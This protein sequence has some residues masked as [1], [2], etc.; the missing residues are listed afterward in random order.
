MNRLLTYLI[1]LIVVLAIGYVSLKHISKPY[2]NSDTI[3]GR[4]S[5]ILNE[6]NKI[7]IECFGVEENKVDVSWHP[8]VEGKIIIKS[9]KQ[10]G[11]IG[12]EYGPNSFHIIINKNVSFKVAHMKTNNWHSHNYK[13]QLTQ[14]SKGYK[15][16]FIA[17]GPN[18]TSYS[19]EYDLKGNEVEKE[20]NSD[21]TEYLIDEVSYKKTPELSKFKNYK[22]IRITLNKLKIKEKLLKSKEIEST[23][24]IENEA[25]INS[26]F[27]LISTK[28]SVRY[29][30]CQ[31]TDYE[32]IFNDASGHSLTFY[33]DT[34]SKKNELL[35]YPQ[36]YNFCLLTNAELLKKIITTNELK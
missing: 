11:K 10:V 25:I 19:N 3:I 9:G 6:N 31:V 17:E 7:E 35:I 20:T 28:Y 27:N 16:N 5:N 23:T 2:R 12:H 26:L 32:L 14:D 21:I 34:I 24:L 13:I 4:I 18:A 36:N 1:L 22:P 15:V 29:C 8:D 30:C 33:L